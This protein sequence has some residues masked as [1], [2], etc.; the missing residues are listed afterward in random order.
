MNNDFRRGTKDKG[1]DFKNKFVK[2]A[3]S[4]L[5]GE[6]D[7]RRREKNEEDEGRFSIVPFSNKCDFIF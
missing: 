4:A 2:G 6:W 3:E 1:R 5:W 7:G